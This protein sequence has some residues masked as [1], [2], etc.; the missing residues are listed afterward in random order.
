M[1]TN[2]SRSLK[3]LLGEGYCKSI[4][5]CAVLL[6]GLDK[7]RAEE[8]VSKKVDFYSDGFKKHQDELIDNVGKTIVAAFDND[9][10]GAPTDS[11]KKASNLKASPIGVEGVY[12]IGEDGRLYIVSKSEHYHTSLGHHFGGYKLIDYARELGI[13]NATHNNTRGYITRI[14]EREIIRCINGIEKGNEKKLL[15]ILKSKK[16]K[17]LNRV[18]N[19]E[20]GSLAVEAGIKMLLARFYKLETVNETPKYSGKT[21]VFFV[22]ADNEDGFGANYHGTTIMAQVMRGM[23]PD[24]YKACEKKGV[25]RIISVRMN[26]IS[27]F[28]AK[29]KK[30]NKGKY[31]TA[32]FL[33]EIILM[34]YGGIRLTE[35]YL[36]QAYKLCEQY[37]TPTLADEIQSCMWYKGMFLFKQYGLKPD[38]VILG[39]GFPGGEYPASKVISTYEMD[40]LSQFGALVTNGQEELASLAYLITMEFVQSN[41]EVIQKSGEYF[42]NIFKE[43]G[44]EFPGLIEKIEGQ[45]H[46]I[47]I[48]FKSLDV[49]KDF[50]RRFNNL[51]VDISVQTYKTNCTH[52]A[53]L[54]MPLI[55][56]IK[57]MDYLCD[58]TRSTFRDMLQEGVI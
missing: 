4:A 41:G 25:Y 45:G 56:T 14:A 53:L 49:V 32:G 2:I 19:L 24:F 7:V 18:I 11:F 26:D 17:V 13:P 33:H 39:K 28:E 29:I 3:D 34:N 8:L 5:E 31:K 30:Y 16:P 15:S 58:K 38:I 27:D 22:M 46:M 12:R 43:L 52:A 23:W 35:E 57:I 40:S 42:E 55:A 54:K 44:N 48:H 6:H 51:C 9:N 10:W 36:Q 20:T 47:A 21:P 50:S 37:D 1:L